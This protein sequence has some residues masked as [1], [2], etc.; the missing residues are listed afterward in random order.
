VFAAAAPVP[1]TQLPSQ[2]QSAG[3][4]KSPRS[5]L[6]EAFASATVPTPAPAA[7]VLPGK[8]E[9]GTFH[10]LCSEQEEIDAA[11]AAMAA[12][13][14]ESV[15][16]SVDAKRRQALL[17]L[18]APS[19]SPSL[20]L[21]PSLAASTACADASTSDS[22]VESHPV[23]DASSLSVF[24]PMDDL[25]S[26]MATPRMAAVTTSHSS[27]VLPSSRGVTCA[28]D[29]SERRGGGDRDEGN[30]E[31]EKGEERKNE[32]DEQER[33]E[34]DQDQMPCAIV[35]AH[36]K[37]FEEEEES[38]A[39]VED[40]NEGRSG[41]VIGARPPVAALRPNSTQSRRSQPL[42]AAVV[43]ALTRA[44]RLRSED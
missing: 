44:H 40:E 22:D 12:A 33:R 29:E 36:Q 6:T 42:L 41:F 21:P 9:D 37:T 34:S 25:P 18:P 13:T 32:S 15:P 28:N 19:P 38:E 20:L 2:Q 8:V 39:E 35:P 11:A 7:D 5:L 23:L 16:V 26:V 30:A 3:N 24:P 31:T 4:N 1:F 14:A 43:L 27:F 17:Q 10:A